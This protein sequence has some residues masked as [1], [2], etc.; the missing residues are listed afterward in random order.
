MKT[1]SG[2]FTY[3]GLYN[4]LEAE[5]GAGEARRLWAL[6]ERIN[7]HLYEKY[8]PEDNFNVGDFVFPAAAVFIA[9]RKR[10]PD[11]DA[12]TLLRSYGTKIGGKIRKI[13]L[14]VT[15]LPFAAGIVHKNLVRIM[16]STSGVDKGYTRKIISENSDFAAVDILSCPLYD[17]TKKI[18]VPEVCQTI[19]AMDKVYMTGLRHIRYERTKSVAEG[20]DCCDYRLTWDRTY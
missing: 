1:I 7:K 15:S 20:G 12:L 19:C 9:L 14:F 3:K 6:A 5:F 16:Y 13:F 2:S 4:E 11:F 18:G 10:Q 8:S 17:M